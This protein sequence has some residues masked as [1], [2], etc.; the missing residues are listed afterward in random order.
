MEN[1]SLM[2]SE[3]ELKKILSMTDKK[4]KELNNEINILAFETKNNFKENILLTSYASVC[5]TIVDSLAFLKTLVLFLTT[6]SIKLYIDT[7]KEAQ[8][9]KKLRE[10][11]FLYSCYKKELN[12]IMSE[13]KIKKLKL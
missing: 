7:N 12:S 8:I 1:K 10:V 13:T 9:E 2:L 5:S 6:T 4:I 11:N 3:I